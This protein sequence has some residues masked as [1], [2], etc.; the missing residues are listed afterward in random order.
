M[1][2]PIQGIE[3][4]DYQHAVRLL[5]SNPLIT[6]TYPDPS[7]MPMIRR[8]ADHLRSDLHTV[9]GYRLELTARTARLI[10]ILD[11]LDASQPA[12]TA[13]D[14]P[15]DRRRYAYLALTLAALGRAGLQ[16]ALSELADHVAADARRIDGLGLSTERAADR[17]AFV[18]AV[19][20]LEIRG[21]VR[22]ADGSARRWADDP[23][24]GEA[25]YDIDQDAITAIYR[26]TRVLQ[27]LSSVSAL[28]GGVNA[29]RPDG[30]GR[31]ARRREAATRVSRALV[32][33]PVTYFDSV[34]D[35]TRNIL[36]GPHAVQQVERLTGLVAERRAEGIAMLDT[37]GKFS[38]IRFPGSGTV[39]Q[40]TLLLIGLIAERVAGSS[41]AQMALQAGRSAELETDL[42]NALPRAGILAELAGA[43][44][45]TAPPPEA[46]EPDRPEPATYPLIEE[47]WLAT[48]MEGLIERY[49]NTFAT[50]L[51][52][53]PERLLSGVVERL[54]SLGMAT[55]VPGGLLVLPLMARYREVAV[56]V[57]RRAPEPTLFDE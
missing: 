34:D 32:E 29:G 53:E 1:S 22:L 54:V 2:T 49:G 12:R 11:E 31:D 51:R 20:W 15:F 4:A 26:P 39:A 38:D 47:T 8:F 45:A 16:I 17:S 46:P 13:T 42:D 19:A 27:H 37:S 24:S 52:A 30:I 35:A 10:R 9:F 41:P 28:L 6:E 18:D 48:A 43:G 25:L 3:L 7:A 5:L 21:A 14:R 55:A 23:D 50:A 56:Q 36:R 44:P 40:A 33:Q 57:R